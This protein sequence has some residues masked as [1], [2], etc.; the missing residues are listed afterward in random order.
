[1]GALIQKN[2]SVEALSKVMDPEKL[3]DPR[4]GGK[5]LT[6]LVTGRINVVGNQYRVLLKWVDADGGSDQEYLQA[7]RLEDLLP[8]LEGFAQQQLPL[9]V[10]TAQPSAPAPP[11]A[12]TPVPGPAPVKVSTPPPA[13]PPQQPEKIEA[14]IKE[15]KSVIPP[16]EPV[17]REEPVKVSKKE[18]KKAGREIP[19][20]DYDFVSKRLPFEVRSLSYGDADGDGIKDVLLTSQNS[21]YLYSFQNRQLE[22]VGEYPGAKLDY[23][24]K[25]DLFQKPGD[26]PWVVL[27]NLREDYA[28]SKLLRYESGKFKPV[29]DNI[30]FQMRVVRRSEGDQLIGT[31]YSAQSTRAAHNIFQLEIVG[32]QVKAMGKVDL[33]WGT[34]LYAYDWVSDGGRED[35]VKLTNDGKLQLYAKRFQRIYKRP[36]PV[37]KITAVPAIGFLLRFTTYSMR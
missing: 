4:Q 7:E 19:L 37:Q 22:L 31:P 35:V 17:V 26:K 34:H 25:V 28:A 3:E 2:Q 32:N 29:I 33:P 36:G 8:K 6:R 20:R 27:T 15:E 1:V 10:R 9:S 21:L 30:P 11:P 5:N 24:V 23:F 12:V 13:P 14:K 16:A 18:E